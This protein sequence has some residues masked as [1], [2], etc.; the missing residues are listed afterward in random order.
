MLVRRGQGEHTD[1]QYH[2]ALEVKTNQKGDPQGV[3]GG[4]DDAVN[5]A[6]RSASGI[7]NALK[8]RRDGSLIGREGAKRII[9]VVMTTARLLTIGTDLAAASLDT[10]ELPRD[11]TTS[12]RPWLWF[13]TN[14]TVQLRHSAP[15]LRAPDHDRINTF[16]ELADADYARSVG[17]VSAAGLAEFLHVASMH[18]G[19]Y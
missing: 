8:D 3:R 16:G 4:L 11:G 17:I 14:L 5:Q 7:I 6:L 12:E 18:I 9:P 2:V 19:E 10:G 1:H 13:R 15:K